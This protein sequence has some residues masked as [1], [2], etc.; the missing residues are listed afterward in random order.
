M[1]EVKVFTKPKGS[2][3]STGGSSTRSALASTTVSEAEHA[4]RADKA[5]RAEDAD[6]AEYADKAGT[7]QTADYAAKAGDIDEG[8]ETL[9]KLL[10]NYLFKGKTEEVQH[11]LGKV[12]FDSLVT[13]AGGV[14]SELAAQLRGGATLG[15]GGCKIT[16]GGEAFLESLQS[17]DYQDA[18][19]RG[20]GIAK[21][22]DG[23][24]QLSVTDL[25]IWGKAV[26]H[27]LEV[28][29]LSYS[30]G[31]VYLSGAGSKIAHV[32]EVFADDG[33]L[34]GWRCYL[35]ADDGTTAT[36]NLWRV[37]DQVRCQTFN[38]AEGVHQGVA[39][40]SYWRIV[41]EVGAE[42]VPITTITE[43]SDG[44]KQ[45]VELYDGKRFAY[46]VV[47]KDNCMEGSDAPA[48]GDTIV[49]DGNQ[50]PSQEERQGVLLLES[51]GKG[52]PRI[53][54]YAGIDSYSH[55]GRE[56]FYLSPTG[57]KVVSNRFEL[58]TPSGDTIHIVNYRGAWRQGEHYDYYDQ[59][60][61]ANALWT[62][63]NSNG[64]ASEPSDTS[65]DWSRVLSGEKGE[66]GDPGEDAYSV[67]IRTDLGNVILN[68]EGSRRLIAH[69]FRGAEEITD[70]LPDTSFSWKRTS[71]DT[72]DDLLWNSRHVGVGN[73]ITVTKE[74]IYRSA[75][76]D[77][78]VYLSEE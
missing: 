43:G 63:T 32:E 67:Q 6:K 38:I 37:K 39:N 66:K 20:F 42:T 14:V 16:A 56:V 27:E 12:G 45:T 18:T 1:I 5:K 23:K 36:Q 51:T 47:A 10:A 33:T 52:T 11:V 76:F 26:F 4:A 28:R 19:Q 17:P 77:C 53:V 41:T 22:K 44:T 24:Y 3:G 13:L 49:L 35:L 72:E 58:V 9:G 75:L 55:D 70:T 71:E 78:E 15:D 34:T 59:V 25:I 50:D 64:C 57:C 68:G 74:D 31:N 60:N 62:C 69:V 29:K 73:Q 48:A 2:D 65:P 30:G 40:R 7:A 61:H 8:S 21:R 54:A 46:I